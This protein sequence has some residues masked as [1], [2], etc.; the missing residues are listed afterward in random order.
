MERKYLSAT[1]IFNVLY[2][3]FKKL[4]DHRK[5]QANIKIS[6]E[7]AN[8]SILAMFSLKNLFN[9]QIAPSD[10]QARTI[11]DEIPTSKYLPI[12]KHLFGV[13]Q[14]G[15]ILEN[16]QFCITKGN[17][18]DNVPVKNLCKNITG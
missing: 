12:F 4:P 10:T 7:D 2:Q 14:R 17:T 3:Q 5:N 8:A 9:I 1:G 18:N 16:F 15:K 6:I 11:L 13:T